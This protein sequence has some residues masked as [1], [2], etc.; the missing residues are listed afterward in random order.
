MSSRTGQQLGNYHLIRTLAEG[1]FAEV[2][3]GEHIHLG[4]NAAIKVLH[5]QLTSEDLKEF[6]EEARRIARLRHPC[7]VAIFDFDVQDGIP[8]LVMEYAPNGTLRQRHPRGSRLSPT[9]ILP[10][11]RQVAG[12]LQY[13]HEERLVHRDV[14]SEN[15]LIG[16]REEI[17]LSDFGIAV[18]ASSTT[19]D[20]VGTPAYMAPEQLQ[21][22]PL[23]ASDQYSLGIVV[24]EWLCGTCPFNGT[25]A[26]I[27][28]KHLNVPPPSLCEQVP[29]LLPGLEKVIQRAL[30]KNPE[31][32]YPT[33][34][35]FAN[36]FETAML[37]DTLYFHQTSRDS[38]P[39]LP[40]QSFYL[41]ETIPANPAALGD[42]GAIASSKTSR[43]FPSRRTVLLGLAGLATTAVAGT[44]ISWLARISAFVRGGSES[45]T[46][47]PAGTP[48]TFIPAGTL[49][50]P[51]YGHF[52]YVY[53]VSWSPN[54]TDIASGSE[55]HTV[56]LWQAVT[57]GDILY[58]YSV[59]T[60]AVHTV[61]WSPDGKLIASGSSDRTV[62]VWKASDENGVSSYTNHARAVRAVAWSHDV[63]LIA[64]GSG[65]TTVQVW[66]AADGSNVLTYSNHTDVVNAVAWSPDGTLIA[67]GGN[68]KTVHV[69]KAANGSD[70]VTYSGHSDTVNA[71]A[72]SPDG[73]LIASSSDDGTVRIWKAAD[74][75]DV[76]AY[77]G[78]SDA[79]NAVAWSPDGTLIASGSNDKTVQ[80]WQASDGTKVLTYDGH[81]DIVNVAAW[82]PDGMLIAS[83]SNDRTVHVWQAKSM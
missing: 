9:T 46:P 24:Y 76:L 35:D 60:D 82:S 43:H 55:D 8:F 49:L 19:R 41:D 2:Y 31:E 59:H 69:W 68:D 65:D 21:G 74:G 37:P 56:H 10:Y 17:L 52:G 53:T 44:G 12:A 23:P 27:S 29:G 72:W 36:A 63:S 66:R 45:P 70:I 80:V 32:R 3:L 15:M 50:R 51:Y 30:A 38:E 26:E 20:V 47:T 42:Q 77:S 22:K 75:S 4:T 34:L 81:T 40:P 14:K 54:G 39:T 13:A 18:V 78:H 48:P 62:Q 1:G 79:V 7:I 64:S 83:G 61:A 71:V 11:L 28:A 73:T 6:R 67:S 57:G 25:F 16:Y 33:V 5:A 58:T